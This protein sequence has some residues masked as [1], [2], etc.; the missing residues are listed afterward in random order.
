MRRTAARVADDAVRSDQVDRPLYDQPARMVKLTGLLTAI[1]QKRER[2]FTFRAESIVAGGI[3]RIDAEDERIF[4]SGLR[5][6]IAKLAELAAAD[7]RIV[8][9]IENE[10]HVSAA[11]VPEGHG[12]AVL[13]GQREI[14]RGIAYG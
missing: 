8:A 3:L 7:G 10:N 14:R 6:A 1:D 11:Q 2:Q 13:I 5:P 9:G 12:L 4:F